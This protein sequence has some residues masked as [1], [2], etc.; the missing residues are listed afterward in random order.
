[1]KKL[2]FILLIAA[3]FTACN[4]GHEKGCKD[5]NWQT[6]TP[7]QQTLLTNNGFPVGSTIVWSS[8]NAIQ[9]ATF[10]SNG[11]DSVFCYTVQ[12]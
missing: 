4:D 11:L 3:T 7:E 5:L 9:K 1:M 6:L 10:T 12:P 8:L 2:L